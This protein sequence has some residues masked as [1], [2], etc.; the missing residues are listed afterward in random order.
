[1]HY[2]RTQA[3]RGKLTPGSSADAI[4]DAVDRGDVDRAVCPVMMIDYVGPSLDTTI[5]AIGNRVWLFARHPGTNGICE[6]PQIRE[7]KST[8]GIS[9]LR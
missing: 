8:S 5:Y 9:V 4:L 7:Y 2:A 6:L 3:V 1:M